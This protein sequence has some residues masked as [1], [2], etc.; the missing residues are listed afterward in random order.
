MPELLTTLNYRHYRRFGKKIFMLSVS[1]VLPRYSMHFEDTKTD[2][3]FIQKPNLLRRTRVSWTHAR[4]P[5]REPLQKRVASV[6]PSTLFIL[7]TI[8]SSEEQG[9][10]IPQGSAFAVWDTK[11]SNSQPLIT[12]PSSLN[13]NNHQT[14]AFWSIPA[15]LKLLTN[16]SP[17]GIG[18]SLHGP[19]FIYEWNFLSCFKEN[20][21]LVLIIILSMNY[22][23]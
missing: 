7:L 14:S 10:S 4:Q 13:H 12:Y 5:G 3:S 1:M 9:T 6:K 19:P 8:T 18:P 15:V 17:L 2:Y 16:T 23:F 20:K 22:L 21:N 11:V